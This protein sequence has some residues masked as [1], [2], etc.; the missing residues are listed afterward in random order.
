MPPH[1]FPILHHVLELDRVQHHHAVQDPLPVPIHKDRNAEAFP[2]QQQP[3]HAQLPVLEAVQ[4]GVW[5]LVP[6]HR[7][8]LGEGAACAFAL[9][10]LLTSLLFEIKATDPPTFSA[11]I[12]LLALV[13]LAACYIPARR[14]A[15]I[16]PIIALRG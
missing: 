15:R 14:A 8:S 13:A 12:V 1:Q 5:P 11:T 16:N 6:V 2:A 4:A 3:L 10:R 7:G 9:S